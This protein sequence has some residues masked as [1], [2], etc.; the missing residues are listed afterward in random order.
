MEAL[1]ATK[2]HVAPRLPIL[3]V[4]PIYR[5]IFQ[6]SNFSKYDVQIAQI[7]K[8]QN[9]FRK[10]IIMVKVFSYLT[11]LVVAIHRYSIKVIHRKTP[12]QEPF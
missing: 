11:M 1:S 4:L 7:Q 8:F 12:V 10:S 6:G 2:V 3:N 9:N 5:Y